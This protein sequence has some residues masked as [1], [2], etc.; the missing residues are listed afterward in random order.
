MWKT[1]KLKDVCTIKTGRKD[2]N[3]G[4][5]LGQYP[6]FTCAK[7]HTFSDGY[8]FDC[9]AIL[10]AGNGAV[11]QTTYYKGKF[12]A[13][14]RTYVLS[15]F[16]NI[17]P[18]LLLFILQGRLM[19]YLSSMVLGNTIPYIKKGM[20]QDFEFSLPPLAEQQRIVA[21]LDA[22]FAEIDIKMQ[23]YVSKIKDAV[24]FEERILDAALSGINEIAHSY[25]LQQLL[26]MGW[27]ESHLDGNHGGDYPRKSEF[28]DEGVPYISANCIYDGRVVMD[29]AKYLSVARAAKL[30]KGIAKNGD[31]L[32]AHNATVGPT[33]ILQTAE[34][35]VIL[36]TSLTYYR[37]NH[38]N[39]NN[40]YLLAYM[41]SKK[42]INQ[43]ND[44]M[45][46][47]TRNQVPITK[48]R[49][50]TFLVP[51]IDVQL[52]VADKVGH[53]SELTAEIIYKTDASMKQ[54]SALKSAILANELQSEAA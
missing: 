49:T 10:I 15:D 29:K 43:Y 34:E 36:G 19:S 37:C 6:F 24:S 40:E 5:D 26:D 52:K 33:A 22:A 12:E 38:E 9:E 54:L 20:L 35:K 50:F 41:R 48:Q 16:N 14:Q 13:Y 1:V 31:V 53:I 4:N 23:I 27:I 30:R 21:K 28:I 3:E 39:I 47:A 32:F 11:G 2:V 45:R 44:V 51:D 8:S 17:E 42:F 46:Q 7:E 18:K 25:T